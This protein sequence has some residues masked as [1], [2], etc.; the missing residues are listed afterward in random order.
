MLMFRAQEEQEIDV[1]CISSPFTLTRDN[2]LM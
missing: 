2:E 1:T